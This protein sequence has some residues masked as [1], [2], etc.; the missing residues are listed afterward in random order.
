MLCVVYVF[1][2]CVCACVAPAEEERVM[3]KK[4]DVTV[5]K[6]KHTQE[7]EEEQEEEQ[8]VEV[9][10]Q[11]TQH[12]AHRNTH[13][14][15]HTHTHRNTP[16]RAN[17]RNTGRCNHIHGRPCGVMVMEMMPHRYVFVVAEIPSFEYDAHSDHLLFL[18]PSTYTPTHHTH[19]VTPAYLE[20]HLCDLCRVEIDDVAYHC[21]AC[22]YDGN[23]H[24]QQ[25][26]RNKA[27][28]A[29]TRNKHT[30]KHTQQAH[31]TSTR[32]KAHATRTRN[33]HTQQAHATH[34]GR[35][36]TRSTPKHIPSSRSQERTRSEKHHTGPDQNIVLMCVHVSSLVCLS[37]V[38]KDLASAVA[39]RA[40]AA[41]AQVKTA[42][43]A[44]AAAELKQAADA[45][46]AADAAA[47][48]AMPGVVS[49]ETETATSGIATPTAAISISV[50]IA[51]TPT[52]TPA[53]SPAAIT[54]P[55]AATPTATATA[56]D[57]S[58]DEPLASFACEQCMK[59]VSQ[60]V[61]C[62]ALHLML[63]RVF[64]VV[65]VVVFCCSVPFHATRVSIA[66]TTCVSR[67]KISCRLQSMPR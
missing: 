13:T 38:A 27:H 45:K 30:H 42:A 7:D 4:E 6:E 32:N 59:Q 63:S 21:A 14:H 47:A 26:T 11:T 41:Q 15:T 48:A 18:A 1:D 33:K 5:G 40:A 23:K 54:L 56:A 46:T 10:G 16:Q 28:T 44:K 9:E 25:S 24:T 29:S 57:S 39:A 3:G 22:D 65:S 12:K 55:K 64:D 52:T 31:T 60:C 51:S 61:C 37:C 49:T 50:S 36:N 2:A 62:V 67:V 8:E 34:N 53:A 19:D 66:T 35:S 17:T 43:D 20:K 58:K